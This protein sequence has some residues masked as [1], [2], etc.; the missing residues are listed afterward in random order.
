MPESALVLCT[1]DNML[2]LSREIDLV[3]KKKFSIV[4]V[5]FALIRYSTFLELLAG[6]I[7]VVQ[8]K[9]T[10]RGPIE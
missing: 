3:W 2:T 1:Y 4:T 6:A 9:F 7:D 5:L 8:S 10:V